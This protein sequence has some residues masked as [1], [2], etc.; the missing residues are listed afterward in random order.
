MSNVKVW[1]YSIEPERTHNGWGIFLIDSTGIFTA[2]SDFGNYGYH[3]RCPAGEDFRQFVVGLAS[4]HYDYLAGKLGPCSGH[5]FPL[6]LEKTRA[7]LIDGANESFI[8]NEL[9]DELANFN[10]FETESELDEMLRNTNLDLSDITFPREPDNDL[11]N[12]CTILMPRL[13]KII[14]EE[15]NAESKM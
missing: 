14:R 4:D 6:D 7:I 10:S 1:R 9:E 5:Q 13:A 3:F 15:L 8:G 11:K 12:F 2:V